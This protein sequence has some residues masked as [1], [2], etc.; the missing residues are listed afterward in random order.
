MPDALQSVLTELGLAIS[1]FR[2]IKTPDQAVDFFRQLG[3]ELPS[4]A[5]S[6]GLNAVATQA[7]GLISA[8]EAQVNANSDSAIAAALADIFAKL[9]AAVHAI[10]QLHDDL[11]ANAGGTP[12]LA[13][14]PR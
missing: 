3:Y 1:P 5:F 7:S 10:E 9:V 4:A 14:L 12:N 6:S 11:Q 8:I 2:A 13:D